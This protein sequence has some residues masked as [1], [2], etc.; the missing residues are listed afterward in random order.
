MKNAAVIFL[1]ALM[2]SIQT[3]VGQLFKL[4]L[5]VEH[6]IKHQKQDAVSLI[7]FL[8]DH[9]ASNHD[10]ADQPEDEQL[11]F[12]NKAFFSMGYAIVKPFIQADLSA[13]LSTERKIIFPGTYTKQQHLGSIFHPPRV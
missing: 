8:E 11:P 9:Y 2:V 3:P 6:Y 4:P 10:D 5:L 7:G 12:K 13:P 1:L